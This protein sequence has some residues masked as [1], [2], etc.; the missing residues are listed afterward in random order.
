[1][2]W[3]LPG[4]VVE[5]ITIEG[6]PRPNGDSSGRNGQVPLNGTCLSIRHPNGIHLGYLPATAERL[7][8]LDEA[9]A[10]CQG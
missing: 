4:M 9:V 7:A 5:L 6:S 2:R 1:M 8:E 10:S 3:D